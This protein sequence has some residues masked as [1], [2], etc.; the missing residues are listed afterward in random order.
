MD[1]VIK[2]SKNWNNKLECDVF[3]TIRDW[4]L[5]KQDY[6][7]SN[8]TKIFD[9]ELNGK[10]KCEAKLIY[11]DCSAVLGRLSTA[12][13]A[14]DTGLVEPQKIYELFKGFGIG[15]EDRVL[16]LIFERVKDIGNESCGI[17]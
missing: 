6:Y 10:K 4:S 2:F 8:L 9:V 5:E 11:V 15:L 17:L 14:M 1:S 7:L 13:L 12:V 3:T 16:L